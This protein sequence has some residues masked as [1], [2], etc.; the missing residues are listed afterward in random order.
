VPTVLEAAAN[1][2]A[3][4]HPF[5]TTYWSASGGL[6]G[7]RLAAS[8]LLLYEVRGRPW[9][10]LSADIAALDADVTKWHPR[11]AFGQA[12][13]RVVIVLNRFARAPFVAGETLFSRGR[14]FPAV[15][16]A[17]SWTSGTQMSWMR[18][19]I[20]KLEG[21]PSPA[22]VSASDRTRYQAAKSRPNES[23]AN[24]LRAQIAMKYNAPDVWTTMPEEALVK[25]PWF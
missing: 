7:K 5:F 24:L 15:Y 14:T 3:T 6:A 19:I 22:T 2:L 12:K 10:S 17:I 20:L 16:W 4:T 18:E 11:P 8:K 23:Y 1:D 13:D 25:K 21:L 9:D